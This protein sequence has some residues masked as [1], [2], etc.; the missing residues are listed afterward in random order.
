MLVRTDDSGTLLIGQPAHAWVSGQLA[1]AWG[2]AAF[3][4]VVPYEEVCLAA[5]QHDIGMA[6]W[7][8]APSW[9]A[10]T[11]LPHSFMEMPLDVHLALWRVA[12]RRLLRQSRYAALLTSIHGVR[13]YEL[14]DLAAMPDDEAAEIRAYLDAERAWQRE[15]VASLGVAPDELARNSQLLWT[16]D[17]MSLAVCLGWPP[18]T[19]TDV[20][21]AAEPVTLTLRPGAAAHQVIVEPWP[22]REGGPVSLRAEGQRLSA[23]VGAPAELERALAAA[24]WETFAVELTP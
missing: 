19:I 16:W 2:N 7:D 21:T 5:E 17:S 20:P 14:R 4:D 11:G 6:E 10:E 13:L 24:P 12:A 3:G 15:I 9:N 1:R 23:P 8:L 18:D 22:F